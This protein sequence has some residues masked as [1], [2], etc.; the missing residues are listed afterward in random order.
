MLKAIGLSIL[1]TIWFASYT[2]MPVV[3]IMFAIG[4]LELNI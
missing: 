2:V 1:D 4:F 3:G